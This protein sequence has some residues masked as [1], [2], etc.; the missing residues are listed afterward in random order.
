MRR[1]RGPDGHMPARQPRFINRWFPNTFRHRPISLFGAPGPA[2]QP[3]DHPRMESAQTAPRPGR[4][5]IPSKSAQ[6]IEGATLSAFVTL[7]RAM[8]AHSLEAHWV[9]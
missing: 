6:P 7:A 1:P 4:D 9:E 8:V 2:D 3:W 5:V